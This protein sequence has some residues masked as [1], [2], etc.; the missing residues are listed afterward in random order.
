MIYRMDS[1]G[2]AGFIDQ[3]RTGNYGEDGY[4]EGNDIRCSKCG[5]SIED[6]QTEMVF[7]YEKHHCLCEDCFKEILFEDLSE[8]YGTPLNEWEN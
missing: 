8:K 1:P 6:T 4:T 7:C 3:M 5:C 2:F